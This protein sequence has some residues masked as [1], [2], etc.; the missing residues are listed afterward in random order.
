M[1]K[2]HMTSKKSGKE[3][4][5]L[6]K[7]SAKIPF[8]CQINLY[9]KLLSYFFGLHYYLNPVSANNLC[10]YVCIGR[11]LEAKFSFRVIDQTLQN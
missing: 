7:N 10:L 3:I 5:E 1:R 8:Y 11:R 4:I 9:F 2:P 6:E